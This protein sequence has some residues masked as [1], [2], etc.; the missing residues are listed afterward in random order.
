MVAKRWRGSERP[1][2]GNWRCER[3]WRCKMTAGDQG[4][5]INHSDHCYHLDLRSGPR[6]SGAS[7]APFPLH[8]LKQADAHIDAQQGADA[9]DKAGCLRPLFADELAGNV[10]A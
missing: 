5:R 7:Q 9:G 4:P 8:L 2:V 3:R 1:A 10:V 6:R